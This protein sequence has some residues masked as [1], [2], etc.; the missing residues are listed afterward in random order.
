M[1]T[2]EVPRDECLGG[3]HDLPA[4]KA[5]FQLGTAD[6]HAHRLALA[7]TS[8]VVSGALG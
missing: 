7:M 3:T 8:S 1:A 4:R 6:S 5:T 2:P